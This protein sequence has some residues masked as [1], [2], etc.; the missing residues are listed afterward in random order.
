MAPWRWCRHL[1]ASRWLTQ[2]RFN[3]AARA[4]IERAI[5]EVESR[6]AGEIRVA[7]ETALDIPDLYFGVSALQRALAVFG[8]LG[9]WDTAANNGVLIYVLMADHEVQI[10][11]DRGIAAHVPKA[12]WAAICHAI[13]TDFR[14]GRY[15]EGVAGGVRA[16]GGVLARHFPHEGGD[17]NELRDEIV[18]L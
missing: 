7:I 14:A 13:E 3:L 17:R 16:V 11:A 2:R 9:V 8:L 18:I 5:T 12:E 1:F 4:T 6:H 15:G 10:V